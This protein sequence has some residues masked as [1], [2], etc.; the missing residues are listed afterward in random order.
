MS[1]YAAVQYLYGDSR[2]FINGLKSRMKLHHISQGR[3]AKQAGYKPPH[4]SRWLQHRIKPDL[5][6]RLK[7]DEALESLIAGQ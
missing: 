3:L 2:V 7:L 6:T 1:L 4:M 5:E